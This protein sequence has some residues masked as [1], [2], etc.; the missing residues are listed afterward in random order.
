MTERATVHQVSERDVTVALRP[1]ECGGCSAC[2]IFASRQQQLLRAANPRGLELRPGDRV[3]VGYPPRRAIGAGFVVLVLPLV[4]F[5]MGFALVGALGVTSEPL[6][7]LGGFGGLAL[8][9]AAA[10]LR[11]RS[12]ADLPVITH[13]VRGEDATDDDSYCLVGMPQ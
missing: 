4:L 2:G 7:V 11:G 8:G 5:V 9:F 1:P 13:I 12:S 10:W 3:E 6:K